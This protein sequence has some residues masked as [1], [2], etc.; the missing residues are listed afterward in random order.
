[1]IFTIDTSALMRLYIPD[2][3]IPEGLESAVQNSQRTNDRLIAPELILVECGQ[4]LHK[5]RMQKILVDEE[6][7]VLLKGILDLPMRLYAHGDLLKSACELALEFNL[8][9]YDGLFLALA[10]RHSAPLFTA[11]DKLRRAADR[12]SL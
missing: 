8:T 5:K 1:M 2:G 4:V 3:P 10:K 7:D 9:V 12:L 6:L 11:D